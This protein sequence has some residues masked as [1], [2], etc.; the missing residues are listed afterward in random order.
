MNLLFVKGK[1]VIGMY[2][3]S[4]LKDVVVDHLPSKDLV[5]PLIALLLVE[6]ICQIE[7]L[8]IL[9]NYFSVGSTRK[10]TSSK[11]YFSIKLH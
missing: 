3:V 1:L 4:V 10:S 5:V 8:K 7:E 9:A 2:A 11:V 6:Q